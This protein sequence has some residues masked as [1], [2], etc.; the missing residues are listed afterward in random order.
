MRSDEL[1]S[2][3][4]KIVGL[5]A[6]ADLLA[7]VRNYR[8]AKGEDR[9]V[10]SARLG[11]AG[12]VVMESMD[13]LSTAEFSVV[14]TLHLET[15]ASTDYW[16]SLLL[17]TNESK[18]QAAELVNL[19]SR[20]MFATSHL[21]NLANTLSS[22]VGDAGGAG[23]APLDESQKRMTIRL[24]DADEKAS[25]PDRVARA[26]DGIDMLYSACAS[27]SRKPAMDL[28]LDG[29]TGHPH[30]DATFTG[31]AESMAAV[32]AVM[33]S[34]PVAVAETNG[35]ENVV[36][37]DVVNRLPVFNDLKILAELGTFSDTELADISETMN[38]GVVLTMESGVA[39]HSEQSASAEEMAGRLEAR[40][41]SAN[42]YASG[43]SMAANTL[44]SVPRAKAN[45]RVPP[46]VTERP[47]VQAEPPIL[48]KRPQANGLAVNGAA[49]EGGSD[50]H[51]ERY[52][53]E[54]EAMQ[55]GVK[56]AEPTGFENQQRNDEV[57]ALLKTL[58]QDRNGK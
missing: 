39:V 19:Y 31:G 12:A 14:K 49:D 3:V 57:A 42:A 27:I 34:I 50:E 25:D 36:I 51:Y 53:R 4:N 5:L 8:A 16:Q 35:D 56:T 52:L 41:A 38:Q 10:A 44:S 13:K 6:E 21:P 37:A 40:S 2:A 1:R 29:V 18:Q 15:L 26:I 43:S 48:T 46:E 7:A 45:G 11:H 33:E 47:E 58:E 28:R 23:Y 24:T 32:L 20:V 54:R 17:S 30:R 9:T 55:K 22:V